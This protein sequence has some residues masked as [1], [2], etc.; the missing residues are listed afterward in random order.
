MLVAGSSLVEVDRSA[1]SLAELLTLIGLAC[2][3][4]SLLGGWWLAGRALGPMRDITREADS[5]DAADLDRRL[6]VANS[7][8][9]LGHLARTLNRL[10]SRVEDGVTRERAFINGAAHDLRTPLAALRMRLDLVLR[11]DHMDDSARLAIEE[12]RSDAVALGELADALLGLA[13]AQATG[14]HDA[15]ADHVLPMLV[16]RAEQDV[17]SIAHARSVHIDERV[18][19][20][21]VR[22]SE[23]R[24]HQALSNLLLNAVRHG[25]VGGI[26]ELDA[27]VDSSVPSRGPVV[28]VEIA[29]RGP[30]IAEDRRD[31]MFQPFA[32]SRP[33]STAHGLGLA[34]AAVRRPV[35][36][37]RYRLSRS[38]RRW[39]GFWF[40]LPIVQARLRGARR[41]DPAPD[42]PS[43]WSRTRIDSM[44][45]LVRLA[46]NRPMRKGSLWARRSRARSMPGQM[47]SARRA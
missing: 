36:G 27:H 41:W 4:G 39:I 15:L 33:D 28:L 45:R 40:W 1:R 17:E 47:D 26:V 44:G 35:A 46:T 12:A 31:R 18:A 3:A 37:W 24:F 19:E 32:M 43:Y 13:D 11:G 16:A 25:P 6:P 5:I 2:A 14:P 9:E 22:V 8:D 42:Q 20:T 10:L 38:D 23:V 21:S 7:G 29:D 34:T 30:G